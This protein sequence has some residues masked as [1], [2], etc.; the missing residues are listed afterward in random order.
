MKEAAFQKRL[1]RPRNDAFVAAIKAFHQ[2][3]QK[4]FAVLAACF[5]RAAWRGEGPAKTGNETLA[6]A[7]Q[8]V[9]I[10]A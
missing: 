10:V 1:P 5:R 3:S 7:E 4:L 9:Y 2:E 6:R 8:K